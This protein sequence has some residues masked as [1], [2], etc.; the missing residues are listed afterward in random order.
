MTACAIPSDTMLEGG[1]QAKRQPRPL[2][3]F[4]TSLPLG[5]VRFLQLD[6][7][8]KLLTLILVNN[9]AYD[10]NKHLVT[11]LAAVLV[12]VL[13]ASRVRWSSW[14]K[15]SIFLPIAA[16]FA[17]AMAALAPYPILGVAAMLLLWTYHF[18]ISVGIAVYVFTST[19]IAEF[20]AALLSIHLPRAIVV[21]FTVMLRFVP[22]VVNELRDIT[23]AMRLRGV[24]PGAWAAIAHPARTAEYVVVPLLASTTRM[25]DDL[26]ASGLLRGLGREG[27]RT[28]VTKLGFTSNDALMLVI[29][30]GI[31]ALQISGFDVR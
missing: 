1:V 27:K 24:F 11:W 25:S 23:Q 18:M 17:Y 7:R 4:S 9:F 26:S 2:A 16:A 29:L 6:P 5:Q 12:I 30:G 21:P 20:S 14:L 15:Y 28:C 8:T 13:L 10:F 31:L 19:R 22:S 3:G